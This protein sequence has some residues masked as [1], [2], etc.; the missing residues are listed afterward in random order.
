[1]LGLMSEL[2]TPE[3]IVLSGLVAVQ[4]VLLLVS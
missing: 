4:L 1:V 3:P 2:P